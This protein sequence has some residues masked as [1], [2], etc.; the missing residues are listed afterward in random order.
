MTIK[1]VEFE[2]I[3]IPGKQQKTIDTR[4]DSLAPVVITANNPSG[5]PVL[6][7]NQFREIISGSAVLQE[8]QI[9]YLADKG[10]LNFSTIENF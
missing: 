5:Q 7:N 8:P 6:V 1:N 9:I 3:E 2:K 4:I 10:N